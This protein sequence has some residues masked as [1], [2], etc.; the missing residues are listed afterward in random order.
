[1]LAGTAETPGKVIT[2]NQ[3]QYKSYV[4]MDSKNKLVPE[5]IESL[6]EY[7]GEVSD[8][9]FQLVGGLRSGMGYTGSENI[10]QL[11]TNAKF[12]RISSAGLVESHPHNVQMPKK[13]GSIVQSTTNII[14]HKNYDEVNK[15]TEIN[16]H[17]QLGLVKLG[18]EIEVAEL[19]PG[20]LIYL[21]SGDMVPA[22]VRIIQSNDLFIN[23]S[24]LTGESMPVEKH[25]FNNSESSSI[26]DLQN[27][28][29][30][31][32]SVVSGYAL[33][34]TVATGVNTYFATINQ[35][36]REK[37]LKVVLQLELER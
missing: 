24:S 2:V 5:G 37:R 1:M 32:T 17:N 34:I 29:Y 10:D 15:Y 33:A 11:R 13:I 23:Q 31:G 7:K 16:K 20:D 14:R 25:A 3:K 8:V 27:I 19:V 9:I 36:I 35:A 22:D 18:E 4:G 30:T 28:C 12:I 21:S 26:L 6:V